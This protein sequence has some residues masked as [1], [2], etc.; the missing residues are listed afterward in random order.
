VVSLVVAFV[1]VFVPVLQTQ[2]D[3]NNGRDYESSYLYRHEFHI[4]AS[5]WAYFFQ[6]DLSA[7]VPC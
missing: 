1:A 3:Q 6:G 4:N 5:F 7:F 2:A